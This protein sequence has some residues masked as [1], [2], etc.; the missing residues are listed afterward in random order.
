MS[1]FQL[2]P[3]GYSIVTLA[4]DPTSPAPAPKGARADCPDCKGT[5]SIALLTSIV[6]CDCRRAAIHGTYQAW[7]QTLLE[8]LARSFNLPPSALATGRRWP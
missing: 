4:D 5:G 7:S 1:R 8:D 2:L 3:K 6:P